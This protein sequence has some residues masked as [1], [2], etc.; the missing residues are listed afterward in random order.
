[1]KPIL[2]SADETNFETLGLGVLSECI[3]CFVAEERNGVF[4]CSFKYPM[5]GRMIK[6][7]TYDRWIKCD[8]SYD[9][10]NQLFKIV[11]I[12]KPLNGFISVYCQHCSYI[13]AQLMLAPHVSIVQR[14]AYSALMDWANAIVDEHPIEID[15]RTDIETINSTTFSIKDVENAR[16]ALG[17]VQGSILDVWGGEYRF[18]NYKIGLFSNRGMNRG[19]VIK[20]GKNLTDLSQEES[21]A[22]TYTSVYPFATYSDEQNQ[23][24]IV[25]L[26]A[27]HYIDSEYAGN[28][29]SRRILRLDLSQEFQNGATPTKQM[30]QELTE[31][32]ILNNNIGIPSVSI[33]LSYLDLSKTIN[34]TDYKFAEQVMLCDTVKVYFEELGIDTTAKVIKV[35]WDVINERMDSVEVGS[36][37]YSLSDSMKKQQTQIEEGKKESQRFTQTSIERVSQLLTGNAGGHIVTRYGNDGKPYE[38]LIMDTDDVLTAQNVWRYNVSGWGHSDSGINGPYTLGATM[39]GQIV[40]TLITAGIL[41]DHTENFVLD[42][43]NGTLRIRDGFTVVSGDDP[44]GEAFSQIISAINENAN[45]ISNELSSTSENISERIGLAESSLESFNETLYKYINSESVEQIADSIQASYENFQEYANN[46]LDDFTE[47][48][49]RYLRFTE[50]GLEIGAAGSP[51]TSLWTETALRFLSN[52]V[53]IAGLSN[54]LLAINN[55]EI[56]TSMKVGGYFDEVLE[57]GSVATTWR[58]LNTGGV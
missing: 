46:L 28:Y 14:S 13:T 9:L 19:V 58:G 32:Y 33:K 16:M 27:P 51:F 52:G 12:S 6:E 55:A 39:D 44:E 37:K 10:K 18:D 38:L 25:T 53:V 24:Q 54:Q 5:K 22:S 23:E 49:N 17:G 41:K 7:I 36:P 1:M 35:V 11:T 57:D 20:Y 42:M 48:L 21:I 2:Y 4:E 45:N 40:A 43:E 26:D 29:E 34:Y 8:A 56:L 30:L 50:Q 3:E 15:E 47:L 31:A